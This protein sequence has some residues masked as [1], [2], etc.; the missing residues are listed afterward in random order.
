MAG[1]QG[2]QATTLQACGVCV[3]SSGG[4]VIDIV[5]SDLVDAICA[6]A[7][8]RLVS[9]TIFYYIEFTSSCRWMVD[10]AFLAP[11]L[12][13]KFVISKHAWLRQRSCLM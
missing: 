5:Y 1:L 11:K 8:E 2:R 6:W 4:T 13:A 9:T 10:G 7:A 12:R 3:S